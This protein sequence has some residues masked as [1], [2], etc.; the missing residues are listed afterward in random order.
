MATDLPVLLKRGLPP[1]PHR[2]PM[3]IDD[4]V[5]IAIWVGER[6]G[7]VLSVWREPELEEPGED[8]EYDCALWTLASGK[9]ECDGGGGSDWPDEVGVVPNSPSIWWSGA[10]GNGSDL[11]VAPGLASPDVAAIQ[12][13]TP[14]GTELIVPR[15]EYPAFVMATDH[16]PATPVALGHDGA[17]IMV[18][19]SPLI[20]PDT[21]VYWW[22]FA[23]AS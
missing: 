17:P 21:F 14:V 11:A 16:L 8:F 18:G 4:A 7:V 5:P 22:L 19:G 3:G 20:A 1:L 2:F 15:P 6:R 23:G 10:L 13:T 9:W 12:L